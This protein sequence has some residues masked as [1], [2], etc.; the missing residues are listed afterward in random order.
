M[1]RDRRRAL[2]TSDKGQRCLFQHSLNR[3]ITSKSTKINYQQHRYI[4]KYNKLHYKIYNTTLFIYL[5][6]LYIYIFICKTEA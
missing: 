6:I 1:W 4:N 3:N 2:E 5:L